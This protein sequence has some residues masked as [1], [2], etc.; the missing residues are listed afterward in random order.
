VLRRDPAFFAFPG[1]VPLAFG[2][3]A[4]I[5]ERRWTV[6]ARPLAEGLLSDARRHDD[7]QVVGIAKTAMPGVLSTKR[8]A[9]ANAVTSK[10]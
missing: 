4:A 6:S 2:I 3:V 1:T 7:K 9:S 5:I 8:H 10:R